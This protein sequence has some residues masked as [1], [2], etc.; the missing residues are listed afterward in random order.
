MDSQDSWA[1]IFDLDGLLIDSEPIQARS[2]N[3]V[4]A[5]YDIFLA[6][7]DFMELVGQ[8]TEENFRLLRERHSLPETVAELL[9]RKAHSYHQLVPD[10]LQAQPGALD[11]VKSLA[12]EGVPLAVASSSPRIDVNLCLEAVGLAAYF[13]IV[14]TADDVEH[15]KPAPDLYLLAHREVGIPANRCV[16]LEDSGAGVQ[17]AAEAGLKC[18]AV[19][20]VYTLGHDF[21]R[22]AMVA[23]TLAELD[24]A[25]LRCLALA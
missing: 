6:E 10:L 17:A 19:P 1:A 7:D 13:P 16:A 4:L 2:F 5:R 14:V 25:S 22:A 18:I 12:S 15:A 24:S 9:A 3:I 11:L 8:T 23:D 21:S 20:H